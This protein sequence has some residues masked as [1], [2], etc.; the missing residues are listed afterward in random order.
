MASTASGIVS[1]FMMANVI[2][3]FMY[4]LVLF[5]WTHEQNNK[6]WSIGDTYFIHRI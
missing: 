2:L 6:Y 3:F 1:Q 5:E 4:G